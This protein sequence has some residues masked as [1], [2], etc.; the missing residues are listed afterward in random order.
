VHASTRIKDRLKKTSWGANI[1][2]SERI[3][4]SLNLVSSKSEREPILYTFPKVF[5]VVKD[6]KLE[7]G[8]MKT[9]K[10]ISQLST[11]LSFLG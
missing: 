4:L 3:A 10:C 8:S 6:N 1:V 7:N 11:V 2:E 9:P 5:L